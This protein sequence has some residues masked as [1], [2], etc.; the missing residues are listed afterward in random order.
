MFTT[1][2]RRILILFSVYTNSIMVYAQTTDSTNTIKSLSLDSINY[3]EQNKLNSSFLKS[4]SGLSK[5]KN[6]IIPDSASLYELLT[7]KIKGRIGFEGYHTSFQNPRML[8]ESQYLRLSGNTSISMGGLPL[9]VDFYRTSET[10]TFYNSNYI[11]VK[12]DYQTFISNITKQWEQQ[13]QRASTEANLSKYQSQ[14]HDKLIIETEKQK[15]ALKNQQLSLETKLNEQQEALLLQYQNQADSVS[16]SLKDSLTTRIGAKRDSIKKNEH[17][18]MLSADSMKLEQLKNDTQR[19]AESLREIETQLQNLQNK[20]R[21]LDSTFNA[22]TA[23]LNQ[24]K[25]LLEDPEANVTSWLKVQG[26]PPQLGLLSRIKDFQTGIINPLI[27]TYSISG[28]S[29]KGLE[30]SISLGK[31]T[32]NFAFGKAIISDFNSYNR[33]NNRY[34]R[35]FIGVNYDLKVNSH[36]SIHLFGHYATDPKSKFINQNRIALQNGVV[37]FNAIYRSNKWPKLDLSYA[38]SSFKALN[39]FESNTHYFSASPYSIS[40]QAMS[41]G[42]YKILAEKTVVKGFA[43]EGSTQMVG[44]RFKNLGNPFMRVNFI[45]H[46]AKTKFAFYKNQINASVFYKTTRDN[47]LRISEVT[48]ISSGYGLSL[49]THF[50]NK[51]LP[52][53]MAS[54]SPYEQGNNHPDSLFRINSK[55]SI[56]TAGMTYRKGKR[57]KYFLMVY[58]SQSRMQFT[59]TFFAIVRTLSVSQDLSIGKKLTVGMGSTFTRTFPSVDSTQANIHQARI[60]YKIG[61]ST[62]ISLNGFS[63]QFLNGAYR[64]GGSLSVSAPTGKHLKISIKAGYDHYYKLWGVDNKEAFWGLGKIEYLF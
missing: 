2:T 48:N 49:N 56:L 11:K 8:S 21:Q 42:A 43:L 15:D 36:F 51:K 35:T 25:R 18:K 12:F 28:V 53:F 9:L 39:N 33:A 45:E 57:T 46:I 7:P 41:T 63:S 22:D 55:F 30:S 61:K 32:L 50:K 37:G 3:F 20:R 14:V 40:Q 4:N 38:K 24:Y 47:P 23:K 58:G 1:I 5:L 17:P 16:L 19:I 64:R 31:Q 27:H 44:P 6:R 62:S 54:L 60:N 29:M 13:M 59:D 26:L 34:E 10:Q 52:N